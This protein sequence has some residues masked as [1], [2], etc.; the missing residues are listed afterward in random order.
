M[1]DDVVGVCH[2][3]ELWMPDTPLLLGM[4]AFLFLYLFIR[5]LARSIPAIGI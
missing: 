1:C 3:V 2:S 5:F 4:I